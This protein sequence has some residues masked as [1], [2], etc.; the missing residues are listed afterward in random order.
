VSG[1]LARLRWRTDAATV[2]A[3]DRALIARTFIYLYGF[4]ATLVLIT[5]AFPADNAFVPGVVVPALLA[6]SVVGVLLV[7]F[8]RLPREFFV[9]L[10]PLGS[11]LI[12]V[13]FV[14]AGSNAS[15]GYAML[16]FWACFSAVYFFGRTIGL[17]NVAW[18]GVTF[19]LG[20][21]LVED[22][23][24]VSAAAMTWVVSVSGLLVA[25]VLIL[26]LRERADRL[27]EHTRQRAGR[28]AAIA[29]LSEL[30]L[31]GEDPEVLMEHAVGVVAEQ[32]EVPCVE[33]SRALPEGEGTLVRARVGECGED[34]VGAL[35]VPIRGGAE[36][37][38]GVLRAH[39]TRPRVFPREDVDFVQVVA[40]IL[41][42]AVV[43]RDAEEEIRRAAHY[44]AVTGLPNRAL[45]LRRVASALERAGPDDRRLAVLVL[46]VDHFKAVNDAF[47]H[48]AG[49]RL[50]VALAARLREA[51]VVTDTLARF[52]GD[53]LVVLC[54]DVEGPDHAIRLARGLRRAASRPIEV[55][56]RPHR[57]TMSVGIAVSGG[58]EQPETVVRDADTAMYRAKER[59]RDREELFDEELRTGVL[60]RLRVDQAL[61]GAEERGELSLVYQPLVAL[62]RGET[63]GVEALL[64]WKHP[65]LGQVS[66]AD[67]IPVAEQSG[68]IVPLGRWVLERAVRQAA[69]WRRRR[70]AG[71][72]TVN[73]NLSARQIGTDEGLVDVVAAL[74]QEHRLGEGELA[75]EVTESALMEDTDTAAATLERLRR[76]GVRI[77]LDDFGT[78]YS[79]LL[80][81]QH[82]PIDAI[83]IDRSF[84]ATL[85]GRHADEAIVA[86]I[87]GM[88]AA[89]ELDV[90]AEGVER[91]EQ[92][93]RAHALGC[94]YAQGYYFARP[95]PA[96]ELVLDV[97]LRTASS[98][99]SALA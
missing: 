38:W 50:V 7:G 67:F 92:A 57:V 36:V 65:G 43:R 10:P 44:D 5:A 81:V 25:A 19:G 83:K 56:G 21:F 29:G 79:S 98:A 15:I 55:D 17:L 88:A 41:S 8:D 97:P 58:D 72:F 40:N 2:A 86:S 3:N 82:F 13:I 14:S 30:A 24:S 61:R 47:G 9:A 51:L 16:Y 84:V 71:R 33:V 1:L 91:R 73:V 35:N 94:R 77:V 66:P 90:V 68:L 63:V 6:Y 23:L 28:Q 48:E 99:S 42:D 60:H 31:E 53:E 11:V 62:P 54:E 78:G 4:G 34:E 76:L 52:G 85:G 46:D 39:D 37:A 45:F 64:R 59:G 70:A 80:H 12:T 93:E 18:V 75:L 69:Q 27:F 49:D 96:S 20:L 26:L 74:L 22:D 32:I 87:A 89:F 95:V